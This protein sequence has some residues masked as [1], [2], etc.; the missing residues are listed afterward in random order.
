MRE[1]LSS[2]RSNSV[3]GAPLPQRERPR[4]RTHVLVGSPCPSQ[5]R[6]HRAEGFSSLVLGILRAKNH[7]RL[8]QKNLRRK[9]DLSTYQR[10]EVMVNADAAMEKKVP[11]YG[12]PLGW[13]GRQGEVARLLDS[14][15]QLS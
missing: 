2:E 5:S 14:R 15:E 11:K 3:E 4:E 10:I 6:G 7:Q 8:S 12:T 9:R 13:F 1:S